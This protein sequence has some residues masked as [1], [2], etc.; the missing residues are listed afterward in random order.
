MTNYYSTRY[1][2]LSP[3]ILIE[4]RYTDLNVTVS[5]NGNVDDYIMDLGNNPCS[6][7]NSSYDSSNNFVLNNSLSNFVLPTNRSESKFI[8]CCYKSGT[9]EKFIWDILSSNMSNK[10]L[11]IPKEDDKDVVFDNFRIHFTSKNAFGDYDGIILKGIIYDTN[12]NKMCLLSHCIK[13]IDNVIINHN[14]M[15]INQKLYTTYID[16]KIPSIGAL[17]K[18]QNQQNEKRRQNEVDEYKWFGGELNLLKNI[19]PT[20]GIMNNTPLVMS[21]Y[22]IKSIADYNN[23]EYYNTER[24]NTISIPAEDSYSSLSIE[25]KEADDGDYF[26][27][28]PIVNSGSTSFS[29]YIYSISNERPD[30]IIVLHELSLTE[31]Y[32]DN[33]NQVKSEVTHREHYIVNAGQTNDG[34]EINEDDLDKIMT[35]RP[36]ISHSGKIVSFIIE[37]QMKIINTLDNTTIVKTGTLKY[38]YD[39][40]KNPS[41]YGKRMNKI[42]L[43]EVPAQ[44]NVYNKKPDID[45]DNVKITNSGTNVKIENHQHSIVGFIECANV[46]VSIECIL[47]QQIE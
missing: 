2:Q 23:F 18:E 35:Y 42:Y 29:D 46:G 1:F 11:E 6:I 43:G 41:K 20:Y 12:K 16:F 36:I 30:T 19:F 32:T 40:N 24:I 37:D 13:K 17:L 9:S 7:V 31:Y 25:L 38:G 34:M 21:I 14:P 4:Y 47:K 5:Q 45:T 22:G 8:Q 44:V 15:L 3:E 33:F 27:I 26:E 39:N 10:P 28:Y